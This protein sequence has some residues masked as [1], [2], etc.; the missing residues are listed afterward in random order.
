MTMKSARGMKTFKPARA[1][2][3][4]VRGFTDSAR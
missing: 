3:L 4:P 1:F 2:D